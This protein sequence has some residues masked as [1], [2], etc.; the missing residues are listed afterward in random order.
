MKDSTRFLLVTIVCLVSIVCSGLLA[1]AIAIPRFQVSLHDETF[2]INDRFRGHLF[3]CTVVEG[4]YRCVRL[5][6]DGKVV[7]IR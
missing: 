5:N 6:P 7:D 1:Y 3:A 4:V 2:L